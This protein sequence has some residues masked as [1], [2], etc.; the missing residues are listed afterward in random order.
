MS[1]TGDRG[2]WQINLIVVGIEAL[3][4]TPHPRLPAIDFTSYQ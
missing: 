3:K 4:P 1:L 2:F